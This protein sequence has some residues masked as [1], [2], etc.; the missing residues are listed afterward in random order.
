MK[1]KYDESCG[2]QLAI[3]EK[4]T[5]EPCAENDPEC[6]VEDRVIGTAR[7]EILSVVHASGARS[8]VPA[9]VSNP[10]LGICA[11]T[12]RGRVAEAHKPQKRCRR[13]HV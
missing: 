1:G 3:P 5:T 6:A 13:D 2:I 11:C 9:H 7:P 8:G 10:A 4:L 12:V